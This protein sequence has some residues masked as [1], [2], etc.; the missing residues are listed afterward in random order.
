M[1]SYTYRYNRIIKWFQDHPI[2]KG[3]Y[4]NSEYHHILP[5]SCG[6]SNEKANIILLPTRWHY[7]VHCWL[8]AVF[9]EQSKQN[10][11]ESMLF[12]WNR[13]QNYKKGHREALFSVK[14]DSLLYQQ[15]KES[16]RKTVGKYTSISQKGSKNSHFNHHW[17]KDPNDKTK[18]MSIK[19]GD[20]IPEGWIKGHWNNSSLDVKYRCAKNRGKIGITDGT[21]QAYI[22]K[23]EEIPIGWRRGI[24]NRSP[25][26]RKK[27]SNAASKQAIEN[28]KKLTQKYYPLIKEQY[29]YWLTHTWKEFVKKYNYKYTQVNF[30]NQCKKYLGNEWHPKRNILKTS[31]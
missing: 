30:N 20:P 13:M 23:I 12:A 4:P 27:M 2:S 11:Y 28:H 22:D 19:E 15:L 29:E 14:E 31:V 1:L 3:S 17:W 9:L 10:E 5:V 25:E 6:G 16:F 18:S 21:H 7:I 24:P 26:S 8:P